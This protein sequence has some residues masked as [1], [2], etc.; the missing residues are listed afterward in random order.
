MT[1]VEGEMISVRIIVSAWG[2]ANFIT[3]VSQ[4]AEI[5]VVRRKLVRCFGAC[6]RK[7]LEV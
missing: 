2:K 7:P 4:W 6:N 3:C 1:E 5:V